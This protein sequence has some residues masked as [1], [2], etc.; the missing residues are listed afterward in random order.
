MSIVR[1]FIAKLLVAITILAGPLAT[2]PHDVSVD[3]AN[4]GEVAGFV[5]GPDVTINVDH[6]GPHGHVGVHYNEF[7]FE[8]LTMA[9]VV[10]GGIFGETV[11]YLPSF[12][13]PA[14]RI[15]GPS[16]PPPNA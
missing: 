8:S 1:Q 9:Q 4:A 6:E 14:S 10:L 11:I 15:A 2:L 16:P 5:F 13:F 12:V 7:E 3:S